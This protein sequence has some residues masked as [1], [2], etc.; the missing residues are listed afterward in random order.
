MFV[1]VVDGVLR[2]FFIIIR[3]RRMVKIF[4]NLEE[5]VLSKLVIY[6]FDC[7]FLVGCGVFCI[8]FVW[9]VLLKFFILFFEE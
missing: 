8:I 9:M 7:V 2:N 4:F 1:N 6:S 5:L 3:I